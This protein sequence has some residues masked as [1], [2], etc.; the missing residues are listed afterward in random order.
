M[1]KKVLEAQRMSCDI[2]S[3]ST[4]S[5]YNHPFLIQTNFAHRLCCPVSHRWKRES[6]CRPAALNYF[7]SWWNKANCNI[8]WLPFLASSLAA[9]AAKKRRLDF[10][11]VTA[12]IRMDAV[13][14]YKPPIEFQRQ[15]TV[16]PSLIS[17][18]PQRKPEM[19]VTALGSVFGAEERETWWVR[20]VWDGVGTSL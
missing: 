16:L 6:S 2:P 4:T 8:R 7:R 20:T 12:C 3:T 14:H 5:I 19:D 13:H 9:S 17:T 15:F 18:Y 1:Y 10:F 11:H